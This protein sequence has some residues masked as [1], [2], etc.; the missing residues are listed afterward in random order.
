MIEVFEVSPGSFR[1]ALGRPPRRFRHGRRRWRGGGWLPP[2][3]DYTILQPTIVC[4]PTPPIVPVP[5]LYRR[6]DG[7][8]CWPAG[9]SLGGMTPREV[10]D[11]TSLLN[12]QRRSLD[13]KR[14][15]IASG[16]LGSI[17]P[18]YVS[19]GETL[20][21]MNT[22][23]AYIDTVDEQLH[24]KLCKASPVTMYGEP[25]SYSCPKDDAPFIASWNTYA[26]E[27]YDWYL[28]N[29]DLGSRFLDTNALYDQAQVYIKRTNDWRVKI[30]EYGVR[31][32]GP[33]VVPQDRD[34]PTDLLGKLF[35]QVLWAGMWVGGGLLLYK[36]ANS[37][38]VSR[39]MGFLDAPE[40]ELCLR[41]VERSIAVE[42]EILSKK[43]L[44]GRALF[45]ANDARI[46]AA[47]GDCE[48]ARNAL[49]AAR[50]KIIESKRLW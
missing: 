12:A 13:A 15:K 25:I 48:G 42:K 23:K 19:T 36:F 28:K 44:N 30:E 33:T 34:T 27:F 37:K 1:E 29:S 22:A 4:N 35:K 50:A 16:N 40:D 41:V 43:S 20:A 49:A 8:Y 17:L 10:Q 9:E 45:L 47:S 18:G 24:V 7:M 14:K 5:G 38:I 2:R 6:P 32:D 26:N 3:I 21:A 39:Q 46:K 11:L 31:V